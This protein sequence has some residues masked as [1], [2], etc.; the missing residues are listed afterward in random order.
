MF[1]SQVRTKSAA[2]KPLST[3]TSLSSRLKEVPEQAAIGVTAVRSPN[4]GSSTMSIVNVSCAV[5]PLVSV[6]LKER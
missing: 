5:Q 1:A 3:E 4:T 2:S 6:M